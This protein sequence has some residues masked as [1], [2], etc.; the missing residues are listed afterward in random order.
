MLSSTVNDD[1]TIARDWRLF[2]RIIALSKPVR[3]DAHRAGNTLVASPTIPPA[4]Q[5]KNHDLFAR[6]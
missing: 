5:I 6:V 4:V 2:F 1:L 3:I